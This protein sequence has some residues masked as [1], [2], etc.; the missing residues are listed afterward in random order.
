[1]RFFLV[2]G[3][4]DGDM[5][6]LARD[7]SLDALLVSAVPELDQR[8]LVQPQPGNLALFGRLDQRGRAGTQFLALGEADELV[9]PA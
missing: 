9:R 5:R 3:D 6:R 4:L 1:V 8:V 2:T 7:G